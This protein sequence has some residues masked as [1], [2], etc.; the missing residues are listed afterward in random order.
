MTAYL[1]HWLHAWHT[2]DMLE[3]VRFSIISVL[4]VNV[5]RQNLSRLAL[6]EPWKVEDGFSLT[7]P[8]FHDPSPGRSAVPRT[9][10]MRGSA[11]FRSRGHP[12]LFC[13]PGKALQERK[14]RQP[15]SDGLARPVPLLPL[16]AAAQRRPG[17]G[18]VTARAPFSLLSSFRLHSRFRKHRSLIFSLNP[19]P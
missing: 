16:P 19:T 11:C 17:N 13:S 2:I 10:K 12:A 7:H 14:P 15:G 8:R 4:S 5:S 9:S 18:Q 3:A 6:P 1:R